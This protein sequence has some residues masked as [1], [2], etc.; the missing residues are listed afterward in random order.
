M[1]WR[2]KE[3]KRGEAASPIIILCN[4]LSPGYLHKIYQTRY[5]LDPFPAFTPR[6]SFF[7]TYCER[8]LP[9]SVQ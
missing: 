2:G 9:P 3:K 1:K 6:G 7:P 8:V 4:S 5:L